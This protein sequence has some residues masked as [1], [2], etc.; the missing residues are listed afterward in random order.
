MLRREDKPNP[1]DGIGSSGDEEAA[2]PSRSAGI[3]SRCVSECWRMTL[4][5]DLTLS[6]EQT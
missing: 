5:V 2:S 1:C 4:D 6:Y 3:G